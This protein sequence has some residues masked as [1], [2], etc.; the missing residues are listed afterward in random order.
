MAKKIKTKSN[1]VKQTSTKTK[2]K[3]INALDNFPK[4]EADQI[5]LVKDLPNKLN[6]I[7]VNSIE[8]EIQTGNK[9]LQNTDAKYRALFEQSAVGVAEIDSNSGKFI[10]INQRYCDILGMTKNEMISTNFQNITHPDDLKTDLNYMKLLLKGDIKEFR[11]EKRYINKDGMIIWV[12]L[13]VSPMWDP[14]Q[15]PTHHIAVVED[16]TQRKLVEEKLIKSNRLYAV[17]SQVNQ[18]IVRT[19]D[20][21]KLF[22]EV[23]RIA[24]DFGKFTMAWIGIANSVTRDVMPINCAGIEKISLARIN[25]EPSRK[26]IQQQKYL[27]YNDFENDPAALPWEEESMNQDCKSFAAFPISVSG[28]VIGA[29]NIY[30]FEKNFFDKEEIQHLDE[31]VMDIGFALESIE[32]ENIR[33]LE[34]EKRYESEVRFRQLFE[35]M[36]D[37]FVQVEMSGKIIN[38]NKSC[39]DLLGYSRAEILKLNYQEITPGKWF[40]LEQRIVEQQVLVR[41]YSDVYEKEYIKKDGTIIPIELRTYLFRDDKGNPIGMWSIVR[42]IIDRKQSNEKLKNSELKFKTLF[43]N[44]NDAIFLMSGNTFIDCNTKTEEIFGCT[45]QQI[46]NHAPSEF[47]PQLQ[48]DGS[49]SLE[50]AS[51]KIKA[52][53]SG[54][55]Q[56]FEWQHIKLDK[57]PFDAEVSLNKLNIDGSVYL[58]AIVRDITERKRAEIKSLYEKKRLQDILDQVGTPIFL[59]DNEHRIIVANHAFYDLFCMEEKN[60]IGYTLAEAVPENEREHFLSVD[61]NVLDTGIPDVREEELTVDNFT[62]TIITRK[63]RFIDDLGNKF[64]VGSIFNITDRKAAEQ[65]LLNSELK[66]RSILK[67]A[68]DGYWVVDDKGYLLEV[69]DSYC[70]IIGYSESELLTMN[71]SEIEAAESEMDVKE[72]IEKVIK[73]GKDRFETSHKRKDGKIIDV[74]ISVITNEIGQGKF[75]AFLRDIT[76]VKLR[77][78]KIKESEERLALAIKGS[79]DAPWD[80]DLVSNQLYYSPQ[81]WNQIGY[82]NDEHNSDTK[83]WEKLMHPEDKNKVDDLLKGA[84]KNNS[85]SYVV[86]FRLKHKDGHYVPVLSRGFISRDPAGNPVRITG[87]NMDLT[88]R[89]KIELAQ[90]E[91]AELYRLISDYATDAIWILDAETQIF[92]YVSPSIER[93]IGYTE[94]EFIGRSIAQIV[95]PASLEYIKGNTSN[96]IESMLNGDR[97]FYTDEIEVIHKDGF[98][99]LVEINMQFIVNPVSG[100]IEGTGIMRDITERQKSQNEIKESQAKYKAIFE[101]TGTA[102]LI[103]NDDRIILMANTECFNLTGYSSDELIGRQWTEFVSNES[104]AEM[105]KNQELRRIDPESVPKKYEAKLVNKKGETRIAILDIGTIPYTKSSIVSIIDITE[106]KIA[107]QALLDSESRFR[108]LFVDAPLGYQSLDDKGNFIDVNRAWSEVLGYEP[109]EIMGKWFGD[110]LTPE[111]KKSFVQRFPL[112]KEQ[113]KIHSEFEMIHKDGRIHYISIDGNIGTDLH[114]EFKQTHCILKDITL[115]KR[116]EESLRESEERYRRL[117]KS[118]PLPICYVNEN[119]Q[120]IFRND[121]FIDVFGY[122]EVKVPTLEEWWVLAYPDEKYRNWVIN[123]WNKAVARASENNTDIESEVYHVTCNDGSV[124][125][126]IISGIVINNDLLA[127]FIDLTDRI[128]FEKALIESEEKF[129]KAVMNAPFPILIHAEDSK[130][131]V[132][133]D[134]WL[135]LTGY[136]KDE[137]S[138]IEEWTEKAYGIKKDLVKEDIEKLYSITEKIDEG[139][140][141]IKTSSGQ[142][143]KWYFSSTP[144]GKTSDGRRMVMSMALDISK[145]KSIEEELRKLKDNLELNVAE[146]TKD[147]NERVAELERFYNATVDREIRMK[148]LRDEIDRL[149]ELNK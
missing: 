13:T 33:R 128:K 50:K 53:Y 12:N 8:P 94:K 20:K 58:Q 74:E 145:L 115:E 132:V 86:E 47:S 44:A 37:S 38:V 55:P 65:K 6:N 134:T 104:L 117:T 105:V 141:E 131:E 83:L 99:V 41:G 30:S 93:L 87:T 11:M 62:H 106:R 68:M 60:V 5:K 45:R 43:E 34:E 72:H 56:F 148:E 120:I 52:A 91:S 136:T 28:K 98:T 23:C 138:T 61:R 146:K 116:L 84:L 114:G 78:Q 36:M 71:V 63:T 129:R 140:Y 82:E 85:E 22:E 1:T 108:H 79:N 18:M 24:V 46:L 7:K 64:L 32:N 26:V 137:L 77:D 121:R 3:K 76:D 42:D 95:T 126:I 149:K 57:T 15:K 75:V 96:R 70:K 31:V 88:E 118:I 122:D 147:L 35:S 17:I 49:S 124:R 54:E 10:Q 25:K 14:G 89:K 119:G 113:G 135:E 2:I 100:K 130:I 142:L 16:I 40:D 144:I 69:N 133:N 90:Q 81:W 73:E 101:S 123:N 125:E 112:F 127:T 66:H 111:Y 103:V 59:K 92:K 67:T 39:L 29:L 80:W 139:E 102:T 143:R 97:S 9:K 110:L 51:E 107:E 19:R 27:I 21:E 48:P 4:T 109:E